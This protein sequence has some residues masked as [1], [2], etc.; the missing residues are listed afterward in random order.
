MELFKKNKNTEDYSAAF[1]EVRSAWASENFWIIPVVAVIIILLVAKF[2]SYAAKVNHRAT[3]K[4]GRRSVKE[5]VL[6]AF[7]II[8]HPFEHS[9]M[10]VRQNTKAMMKSCNIFPKD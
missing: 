3:L 9:G 5:E 10:P 1:K 8:F 6:Y 2:F 4:L 7:H